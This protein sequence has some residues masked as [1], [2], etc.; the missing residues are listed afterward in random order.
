[1]TWL[2]RA[3][4]RRKQFEGTAS[5]A[6]MGKAVQEGKRERIAPEAMMAMMGGF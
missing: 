2:A 1:L 5:L 3:Y 4:V 6:A